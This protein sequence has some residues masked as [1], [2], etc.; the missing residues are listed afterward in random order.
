MKDRVCRLIGQKSHK[1]LIYGNLRQIQPKSSTQTNTTPQT[2]EINP[3][4]NCNGLSDGVGF[5]QHLLRLQSSK[6]D[7]NPEPVKI[8]GLEPF[9]FEKSLKLTRGRE[10]GSS[11]STDLAMLVQDRKER[12]DHIS[13]NID[14][15]FIDN[16]KR[17]VAEEDRT[18]FAE[19]FAKNDHFLSSK[20]NNFARKKHYLQ[21]HVFN[22]Y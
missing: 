22:K 21:R 15:K 7:S 8:S 3:N 10:I 6:F 18:M 13:Q 19:F 11:S 5:T 20:T 1:S 2:I 12:I 9:D 17:M 4:F 16:V 14:E